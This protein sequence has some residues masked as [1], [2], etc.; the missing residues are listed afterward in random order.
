MLGKSKEHLATHVAQA[1]VQTP[2]LLPAPSAKGAKRVWSVLSLLGTGKKALAGEEKTACHVDT[3]LGLKSAAT[4]GSMKRDAHQLQRG[5][6]AYQLQA[7]RLLLAEPDGPFAV[8]YDRLKSKMTIFVSR[9]DNSRAEEAVATGSIKTPD[10]NSNNTA[11]LHQVAMRGT[12]NS[13][14]GLGSPLTSREASSTSRTGLGTAVWALVPSATS[15]GWDGK[16]VRAQ[17]TGA[18]AGRA[19]APAPS[20]ARRQPTG[21]HHHHHLSTTTTRTGGVPTAALAPAPMAAWAGRAAR[22]P[23]QDHAQPLSLASLRSLFG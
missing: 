14:A 12:D 7:V 9:L 17:H 16:V 20:A 10:A 19:P 23:A 15:L 18:K 2:A 3:P 21:E 8:P 6:Q 5:L 4:S 13:A 11:F 1:H 22:G